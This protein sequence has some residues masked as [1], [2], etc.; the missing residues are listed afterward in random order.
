MSEVPS[1]QFYTRKQGIELIR[2]ELGIP[3]PI[4]RFEKDAIA[5]PRVAPVPA[6]QYGRQ[7]LYTREQLLDY[8]R[9]LI[10]EPEAA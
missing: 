5:S 6:A 8:A 9:R 10:R 1:P 3:V 7:E 2:T 4:S